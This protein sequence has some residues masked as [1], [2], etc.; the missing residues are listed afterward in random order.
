MTTLRNDVSYFLVKKVSFHSSKYIS[1]V[2]VQ[3]FFFKRMI[4]LDQTDL[5]SL[6][7]GHRTAMTTRFKYCF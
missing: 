3:L 4:D 2:K 5:S 1:L 7:I 6:C